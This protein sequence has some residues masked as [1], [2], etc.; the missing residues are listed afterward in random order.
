MNEDII[1]LNSNLMMA[2]TVIG[3][4]SLAA[5]LAVKRRARLVDATAEHKKDLYRW[6]APRVTSCLPNH[7]IMCHARS[8]TLR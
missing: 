8:R 7:S 2:L 3:N 1:N 6:E 4:A 5:L